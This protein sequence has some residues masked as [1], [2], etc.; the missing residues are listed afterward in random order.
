MLHFYLHLIYESL[1]LWCLHHDTTKYR[2]KQNSLICLSL[3]VNVSL[4]TL[5][6]YSFLKYFQILYV[7]N[8]PLKL[9]EENT[10]LLVHPTEISVF[11][12]G[13]AFSQIH[14][15]TPIYV[16]QNTSVFVHWVTLTKAYCMWWPAA[17]EV[18]LHDSP[19]T[20]PPPPPPMQSLIGGVGLCGD[21][22]IHWDYC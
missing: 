17:Y 19:V 11:T 15:V 3:M 2:R 8:F 9:Q 18:R 1:L 7:R 22:I 5:A 10:I 21:G 13:P 16:S 4:Q 14:H 20:S 6:V 12:S